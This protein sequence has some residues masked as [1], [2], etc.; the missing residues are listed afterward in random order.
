MKKPKLK[1]KREQRYQQGVTRLE[2]YI[3]QNTARFQQMIDACRGKTYE[4]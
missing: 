1:S 3:E 2:K 4:R